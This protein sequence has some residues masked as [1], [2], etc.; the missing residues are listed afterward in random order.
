MNT[1]V[2]V[3]FLCDTTTKNGS[4]LKTTPLPVKQPQKNTLFQLNYKQ[5]LSFFSFG[6][7]MIENF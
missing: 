2:Y 4:R 5:Y 6:I 7:V 3:V 1:F